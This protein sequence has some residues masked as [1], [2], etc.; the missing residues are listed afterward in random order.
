MLRKISADELVTL[1]TVHHLTMEQIGEICGV[2][3]QAIWRR[4]KKMG[5]KA[6]DGEWVKFKCEICGKDVKLR[7]CEFRY[8]SPRFCSPDCY[9][10]AIR[11][12]NY[13]PWRQGG[14]IAREVVSK[15]FDI[16]KYPNAVIH[17]KDGNNRNNSCSNLVVFASQAD[18]MA[19]HRGR[20]V[21]PL[22]DGGKVGYV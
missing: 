15:Y 5:V 4:L 9:F 14:R 13:K 1:Y 10:K 3:R 11:N 6:E 22:W 18:H 20:N 19:Y 12:P 8:R 16:S 7:R 21:K 17:H 2:T